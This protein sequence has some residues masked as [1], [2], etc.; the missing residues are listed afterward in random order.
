MACLAG[1]SGPA[2]G[3]PPPRRVPP[4]GSA[5]QAKAPTRYPHLVPQPH[6]RP[7]R[8]DQEQPGKPP[9]TAG[10]RTRCSPQRGQPG[11]APCPVPKRPPRGRS[12]ASAPFKQTCHRVYAHLGIG[13]YLQVPRHPGPGR[14]AAARRS[15][16]T[17]FPD[18][19]SRGRTYGGRMPEFIDTTD[20]LR[21]APGLAAR[22]PDQAGLAAD[23]ASELADYSSA[24]C[25]GPL[26]PAAPALPGRAGFTISVRCSHAGPKT[27]DRALRTCR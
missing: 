20:A 23:Q 1:P 11:A 22:R 24:P 4:H 13:S 5:R 18:Y 12:P 9:G 14:G 8:A 15:K 27:A 25:A 26:R 16:F 6:C 21:G 10:R 3:S 7:G 17:G 2:P 19:R